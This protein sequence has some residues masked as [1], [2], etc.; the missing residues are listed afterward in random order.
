[1]GAWLA[2]VERRR[3][4]KVAVALLVA[5]KPGQAQ[6][7]MQRSLMRQARLAGAVDGGAA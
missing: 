1:M 3:S 6:F 5:G 7:V 4:V 2:A